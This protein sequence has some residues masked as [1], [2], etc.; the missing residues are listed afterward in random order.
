LRLG[1][2]GMVVGDALAGAG[3]LGDDF[4]LELEVDVGER[5]F[6][7]GDDDGFRQCATALFGGPVQADGVGTQ[8]EDEV[9]GDV[10]RHRQIDGI[11]DSEAE[12]DRL[13]D[14]Q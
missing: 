8:A 4:F 1:E 10:F 7:D 5:G 12:G 11:E 13:A 2:A 6:F 3:D 14:Q 9:D